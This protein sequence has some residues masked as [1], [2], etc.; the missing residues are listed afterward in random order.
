MILVFGS[1][2]IDIVIAV[3]ALP[4]PGETVLG[5]SYRLLPGGKGANQALA[6]ARD[7][8]R[9]MLAGAV[10]DDAFADAALTLLREGGVDLSLVR[11]VTQPT[12]CA[13]ISVAEG[14]GENLITVASGANGAVTAELVPDALL[15]PDVTLLLQ[16]ELPTAETEQLIARAKARGARIVLNLAPARPIAHGALRSVDVL[17]VNE[18]EL[19]ALAADET[20]QARELGLVVVAT[21]GA[22]GAVAVLPDGTRCATPALPITPVDTTGA[23]DTFTGVLAAAL[24][25]GLA[26]SPALRRA[27]VAAGLACL[28]PGAQPGMPD[29]ARNDAAMRDLPR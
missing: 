23:G 6:A 29:R 1:I 20:T 2:N 4:K 15:G 25:A 8:A 7:G 14:S 11:T 18:G 28:S 17:V 13:I 24:D 19:A 12:G 22:Q 26:L 9:V 27:S 5:E 3:P 21:R 10:G 16:M